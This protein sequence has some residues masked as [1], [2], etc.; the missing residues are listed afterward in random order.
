MCN[1]NVGNKQSYSV[2]SQDVHLRVSLFQGH[3][4]D[5]LQ[6]KR[7]ILHTIEKMHLV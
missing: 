7:A 3:P 1:V 2:Q 4:R 5:I 6:R